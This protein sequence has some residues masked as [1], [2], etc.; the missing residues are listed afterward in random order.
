MYSES[1]HGYLKHSLPVKDLELAVA[2]RLVPV[3][4]GFEGYSVDL[5]GRMKGGASESM[6]YSTALIVSY[7]YI[8]S[9]RTS[10]KSIRGNGLRIELRSA[11]SVTESKERGNSSRRQ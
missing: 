8:S 11:H 1:E 9:L 10:N 2:I 3:D 6:L 7:R 4:I 5:S